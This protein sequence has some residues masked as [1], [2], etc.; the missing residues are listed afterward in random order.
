MSLA[1]MECRV[2]RYREFLA[3]SKCLLIAFSIISGQPS[4]LDDNT[5][6]T[7]SSEISAVT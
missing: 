2:V 6:T 7:A 5:D 4:L 3:V 1:A